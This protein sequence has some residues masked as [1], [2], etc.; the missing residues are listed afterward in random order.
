VEPPTSPLHVVS[1]AIRLA[2]LVWSI[3]VVRRLRDWRMATLTAL[4]ALMV[5]SEAVVLV[6]EARGWSVTTLFRMAELPNLLVSVLALL[7]VVVCGW[8]IG[9]YR[10]VDQALTM[11]KAYL[12]ELFESAPQAT[13]LVDNESR[14]LRANH[15]FT[16]LFGYPQD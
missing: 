14:V 16:R 15:E 12:E 5:A 1:L 11:E 7:A 2:A 13:V 6:G 8:V 3:A 4:L 10:R 9:A